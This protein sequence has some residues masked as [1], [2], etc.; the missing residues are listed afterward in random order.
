MRWATFVRSHAHLI[1]AADFFTTEV[2]A[3]RGLVRYFT[4]FVIDIAT[5][6]VCIA[7]TTT[8]PT[9]A[10]MEQI[11][12]NLTDCEDGFL[13]GKG[14]LVIDRDA[15]FS[16][17]FQSILGSSGV[18]ILLTAYQAPNMNAHAERFVRSIRSECLDQMIF[19][20]RESL[21]RAIAEFAAHYH[22][23]RSHQGIGNRLICGAEAQ[24]MGCVEVTQRLG[25]LLNYYQRQA[26]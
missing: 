18:D 3:A 13:T 1:A 2:W 9:T 12:R 22:D 25:G 11:A 15:K 10:W 21:V 24:S 4:L 8:N 6:R 26:A 16:P 14:F 20:G 19:L 7:G 5:R 23:E 17:R